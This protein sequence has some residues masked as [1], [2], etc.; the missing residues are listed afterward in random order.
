MERHGSKQSWIK[1]NPELGLKGES[2][3][4]QFGEGAK[5]A[6]LALGHLPL[7][8]PPQSKGCSC[9]SSPRLQQLDLFFQKAQNNMRAVADS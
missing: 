7:T 1:D 8:N 3:L 5:G 6:G 2:W 4:L 9:C